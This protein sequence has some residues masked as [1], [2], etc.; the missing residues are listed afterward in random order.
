MTPTSLTFACQCCG[1][2]ARGVLAEAP[3]PNRIEP[4]TRIFGTGAGSFPNPPTHV[5]VQSFGPRSIAS[6]SDMRAHNL[7]TLTESVDEPT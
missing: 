3:D 2:K 5:T 7:G 1:L 4:V 6:G